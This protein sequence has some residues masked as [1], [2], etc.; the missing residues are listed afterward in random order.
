MTDSSPSPQEVDA[1]PLEPS[2]AG[3]NKDNPQTEFI[4]HRLN[5]VQE[6]READDGEARPCPSAGSR[7]GKGDVERFLRS[8]LRNVHTLFISGNL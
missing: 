1:T 4:D 2:R 7:K 3:T 6:N 5:L 8:S